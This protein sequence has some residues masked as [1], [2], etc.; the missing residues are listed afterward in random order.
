M[1]NQK[2]HDKVSLRSKG[3]QAITNGSDENCGTD[4]EAA[5]RCEMILFATNAEGIRNDIPP[6]FTLEE[7][8]LIIRS[9]AVVELNISQ[10]KI[11]AMPLLPGLKHFFPLDR[12][13]VVLGAF[14]KGS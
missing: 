12:P 8:K 3:N 6:A 4:L 13:F 5:R 1:H 9:W 10:V 11:A 7:R 14:P 2:S